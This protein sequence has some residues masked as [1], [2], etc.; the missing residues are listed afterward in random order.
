[1]GI[2]AVFMPRRAR[3]VLGLP[4]DIFAE[5]I[6][7]RAIGVGCIVEGRGFRFGKGRTGTLAMLRRLGHGLGFDVRTVEPVKVGGRIVSSTWVRRL[8][9]QGRVVEA[10]RCLGRPFLLDGTVTKWERRGSILGFPTVNLKSPELIVPAEGVYAGETLVGKK[11]HAAAIC[12]G[13]A[14]TFGRPD[15]DMVEAYLLDF[16]RDV[17]GQKV[18]VKFLRRLRGQ[19]TF[20]DAEALRTQ[21]KQDCRD[22]RRILGAK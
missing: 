11:W 6:L 15:A 9:S 22:V 13:G 2:D 21:M 12:V 5:K 17:Y 8:L 3:P 14:P 7:A 1:M 4:P 19:K 20:P 10:A 18:R 16:N